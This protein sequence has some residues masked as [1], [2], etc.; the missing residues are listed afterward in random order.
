M[1]HEN[2]LANLKLGSLSRKKNKTKLNLT[3]TPDVANSLKKAGNAS[4]FVELLLQA[5]QEKRL[6]DPRELLDD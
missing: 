3:V 4:R 6:L 5:H 2:S 1:I